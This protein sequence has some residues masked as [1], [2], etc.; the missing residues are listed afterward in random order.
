MQQLETRIFSPPFNQ[1][2]KNRVVFGAARTV[3][4]LFRVFNQLQ[5]DRPRR[6]FQVAKQARRPARNQV[7]YREDRA[8][9]VDEASGVV[10]VAVVEVVEDPVDG[11]VL[12]VD[13]LEVVVESGYAN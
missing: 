8:D 5:S 9:N 10:A 2:S 11:I 13:R 7:H 3:P 1:H 4:L 12:P 6:L